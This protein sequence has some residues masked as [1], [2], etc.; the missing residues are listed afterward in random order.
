M[1]N[2]LP[3]AIVGPRGSRGLLRA[4]VCLAVAAGMAAGV[5]AQENPLQPGVSPP[6]AAEP[7]PSPPPPPPPE[8]P[9]VDEGEVADLEKGEHGPDGG[10]DEGKGAG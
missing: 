10:Q 1:P 9:V 8:Q 6:R 2:E 3:M 4:A 7:E 5:V